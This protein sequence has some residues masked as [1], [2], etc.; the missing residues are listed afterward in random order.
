[1]SQ[2]NATKIL[3]K[4]ENIDARVTRLL[5][6]LEIKKA[7]DEHRCGEDEVWSEELQQC[8]AK[9]PCE[10]GEHWDEEQQK[11]VPDNPYKTE[12]AIPKG[13]GLTHETHYDTPEELQKQWQKE[14]KEREL[15][16]NPTVTES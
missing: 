15:S 12:P 10:N 7:Q 3:E 4:L 2:I 13:E 6:K 1:M 8:V 5:T 16:E 14:D 11:C 9:F